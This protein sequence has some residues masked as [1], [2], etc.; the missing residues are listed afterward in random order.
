MIY[1][2]SGN[3]YQLLNIFD[4]VPETMELRS[5][6]LLVPCRKESKGIEIVAQTS[7]FV[8]TKLE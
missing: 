5:D 7:E 2:F 3:D 4:N 8:C 1:I 6:E